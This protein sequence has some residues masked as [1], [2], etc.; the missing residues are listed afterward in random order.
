[1]A[2]AVVPGQLAYGT[3]MWIRHL[4]ASWRK[5]RV[6]IYGHWG[7][8]KTTLNRQMS[9]PGE[10]EVI[11]HDE[12]ETATHHDF[13]QKKKKFVLTPASTK[14][15]H[16]NANEGLMSQKRTIETTDLGGHEEYFE[17]WLEDMV[18]RKVEIVIWLI[19]H[20]HMSDPKNTKQQEL[21]KKFVDILISGK[22]PFKSRKLRKMARGYKPKI[23]GLIA[24]KA[25]LWVDDHWRSLYTSQRIGEHPIYDPFRADL[26][27][28]QRH[29]MIPTLKRSCSALRNWNVERVV[30]DLLQAKS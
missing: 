22:F 8:G 10:L 16:L 9:T 6:G 1:M 29:L 26:V 19:D 24:N 17:L 23:I 18:T 12:K 11:A 20:R 25:D 30:W 2:D 5:H 3:I 27:R 14:R 4:W 21:F 13:N 28:L 15:V 7:T